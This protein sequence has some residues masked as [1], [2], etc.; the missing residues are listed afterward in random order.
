MRARGALAENCTAMVLAAGYGTRLE[1]LTS[2]RAKAVVPF[3]NRPLLDYTLDWLRRCGFT[4]AVINLHHHA[5]GVRTRY[6]ENQF[7]IDLHFSV[8][9]PLL[10]TAGGP[11][12][13]LDRLGARVLIV[14]GDVA[15]TIAPGSL[16]QHHCASGALATMA[17]HAGPGGREYPGIEI[18]GAG[19]VTHIPGLGTAPGADRVA[20]SGA[21]GAAAPSADD[22]V[23]G[24]FTG[25]HIVEREVLEL[26]PEDRFCGLVD[27]IYGR[28]LEERLPLHGVVVPGSWYEIGTPARY[29]SCQLEALRREDFPLAFKGY[30][31]IAPGGYVRAP[32]GRS[33][34]G[35]R[36]P[37][38]LDQQ[39]E[40]EEAS[41][42]EGVIAGK[43]AYVG[44]G[45]TVRDSVLMK[46][47]W[48][49]TGA[50]V[51]RCIV[52]EDAVV[53]A[54]A[55]RVDEVIA[56]EAVGQTG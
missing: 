40:L 11:R 55:R 7:G 49:G 27:P 9:E 38:M 51:E 56:P 46:R 22:A 1:P 19:A 3:L 48:I 13:V 54:G 42:I 34:A 47:A 6:R 28:L 44:Y 50:H 35:M 2:T 39:V 31:R 52:L 53:P 26:V 4:R 18:D 41:L 24:C 5:D 30:R 25:I 17:L 12:K 37:F 8:E 32:V 36:P 43:R 20:T 15:T 21:D 16:W 29:L 23:A 33:R 14:N 10:G 45:A